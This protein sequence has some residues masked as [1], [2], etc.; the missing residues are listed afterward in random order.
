MNLGFIS[1][2]RTYNDWAAGCQF[3][4]VDEAKDVSREDF[5][6][7]YETF[8]TRIDT[9]PVAF[10]SNAKYGKTKDD[11]MWFNCLIFTNH[12]D[13]MII[14]EDDRRI[15]VLS[16]P[17]LKR[18]DDYYMGLHA[19]LDDDAEA[20]RFYWY[21]MRRDVR[22]FNPAAP[23][24]TPAKIQMID[25]SKSPIDEIHEHLIE[26]MAGDVA[27][28]KQLTAHVKRVA[29]SLGFDQIEHSP[30]NAVRR[31]WRQMQ[32]LKPDEKNGYRVQ[33][34]TTR[35]EIRALRRSDEW[36]SQ[37]IVLSR[38]QIVEEMRKNSDTVVN[39]VQST[40]HISPQS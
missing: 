1:A 4:I 36:L 21:L 19:A 27:T 32:S 33:I 28:R 31:I 20:R 30:Q 34:D 7:A 25:A 3:L 11:T 10:R 23:P 15:A 17:T 29:R 37:M 18:D 6:S 22:Q 2:D 5:W 35:E 16:N 24:M 12:A 26:N 40:S 14:P 39:L 8:K 13:A 38:E 9:S